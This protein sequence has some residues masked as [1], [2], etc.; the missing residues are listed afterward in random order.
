[1]PH[2]ERIQQERI[3]G[4]RSHGKLILT[5]MVALTYDTNGADFTI[6]WNPEIEGDVPSVELAEEV[7]QLVGHDVNIYFSEPKG[8]QPGIHIYSSPER[9][10]EIFLVVRLHEASQDR[11]VEAYVSHFLRSHDIAVLECFRYSDGDG[12]H[13]NLTC[14]G[15][16]GGSSTMRSLFDAALAL[17]QSTM[18]SLEV[19]LNSAE[20]AFEVLKNGEI[21][22]FI[23]L[24]ENEWLEVKSQLPDLSKSAGKF[25]LAKDV[26]QFANSRLGGILVYGMFTKN[27]GNG[28]EICRIVPISLDE[29]LKKS[30]E[31]TLR[32][33]V[34]PAI[35]NLHIDSVSIDG[36]NL[37]YLYVPAQS[38]PAKPFI[39]E[40]SGI[41][42]LGKGS[43]FAVPIRS[44]G[45]TV[46][47]TGKS[48]HALLAGKISLSG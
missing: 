29:R 45:Q 24:H 27:K 7:A 3:S 41:V 20:D 5:N 17:Q 1:M 12:A 39:V 34:H 14:R 25:T 21:W 47:I 43:V 11:E 13:W 40:G 32:N 6:E 46:Q 28:D 8:K 30:I 16:G 36:G 23:G 48:L 33:Q 18:K 35:A 38:D 31:A 15:I 42:E 4:S 26:A 9:D 2:V 19:Q 44:G 37:L 10:S 22:R